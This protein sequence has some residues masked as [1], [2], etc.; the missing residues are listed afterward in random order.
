MKRFIVLGLVA[1]LAACASTI[2]QTPRQRAYALQSDYNGLLTA[3]VAYESQPRC[4]TVVKISCSD[5]KAVA[6]IRK[7]DN[8]AYSA[9]ASARSVAETATDGGTISTALTAAVNAL[10]VL[11][12]ALLTYGA[13][14]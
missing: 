11:R 7:A 4:T 12:T 1:L 3:A 14:K 13:L 6:E 2:A 8:V 10:G 5:A 9:I